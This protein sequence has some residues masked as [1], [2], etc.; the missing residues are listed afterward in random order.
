[1]IYE[2]DIELAV[3]KAVSILGPQGR[4]LPSKSTVVY[5]YH[6]YS[7]AA[8]TLWYGDIDIVDDMPKIKKIS[9]ATGLPLFVMG[10]DRT[11]TQGYQVLMNADAAVENGKII[12]HRY[13]AVEA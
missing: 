3:S 2:E 6:L 11:H 10:Q 8:G 4:M 9:E 12:K 5:N 13:I 7:P 1:M